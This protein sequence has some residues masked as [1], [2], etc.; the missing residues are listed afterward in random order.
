MDTET[1]QKRTDDSL[2]LLI[3]LFGVSDKELQ[4]FKKP[5]IRRTLEKHEHQGFPRTCP[6]YYAL[7]NYFYWPEK[8]PFG[9][10]IFQTRFINHEVSHYI[11]H[12][13]NPGMNL[14]LI[15]CEETGRRPLGHEA[16]CEIVAEYANFILGLNDNLRPWQ[17]NVVKDAVAVYE[18]YGPSFLPALARMSLD[19]AIKTNIIIQKQNQK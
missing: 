8:D 4:Y 13:L 6:A 3:A 10:D 5:I 15:Q 18:E 2:A 14:G 7:K 9:F 1:L 12:S 17:R 11:H 16:F 19:E